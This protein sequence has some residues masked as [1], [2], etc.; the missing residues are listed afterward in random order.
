MHLAYLN[1]LF[2]PHFPKTSASKFPREFRTAGFS[3]PCINNQPRG[4]TMSLSYCFLSA[5]PPPASS[6][7]DYAVIHRIGLTFSQSLT[8]KGARKS[9]LDERSALVLWCSLAG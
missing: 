4:R 8:G 9:H 2:N 5:I 3:R 6:R 1:N 7:R